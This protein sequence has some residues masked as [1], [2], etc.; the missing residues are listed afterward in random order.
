[1][2][3]ILT[4]KDYD[5]LKRLASGKSPSPEKYPAEMILNKATNNARTRRYDE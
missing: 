2:T 1:M 5:I 3:D 4:N